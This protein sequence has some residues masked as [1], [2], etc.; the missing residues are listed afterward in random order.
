MVAL[1]MLGVASPAENDGAF[2]L[3]EMCVNYLF[4]SVIG[5]IFQWREKWNDQYGAP[6]TQSVSIAMG[7]KF[8]TLCKH[9]SP[10]PCGVACM[11]NDISKTNVQGR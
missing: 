3:F 2:C 9:L 11:N 1:R 10:S 7:L 6:L 4:K 5:L 8:I